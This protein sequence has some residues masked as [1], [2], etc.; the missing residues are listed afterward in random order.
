M[1]LE[2]RDDAPAVALRL[3]LCA[4]GLQHCSDLGGMVGI[5]IK[6]VHGLALHVDAPA[7]LKSPAHTAKISQTLC[8]CGRRAAGEHASDQGTQ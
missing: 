7:V 2:A 5:V 6:D 1:R 3:N 8:D 4:G